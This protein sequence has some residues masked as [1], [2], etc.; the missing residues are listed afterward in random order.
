MVLLAAFIK[1][2]ASKT[3]GA[4]IRTNSSIFGVLQVCSFATKKAE[5]MGLPRCFFDLSA[6]NQ[7]LGRI[8]IEVSPDL[9]LAVE[10]L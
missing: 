3:L 6:D 5:K 8:I 2:T 7:P 4:G 9:N 10:L 1:Q